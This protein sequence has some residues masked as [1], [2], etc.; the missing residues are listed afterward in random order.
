MLLKLLLLLLLLLRRL[1]TLLVMLE[2]LVRRRR[3]LRRGTSNA[4]MGRWSGVALAGRSKVLLL[5]LLLLRRSSRKIEVGRLRN[6]LRF[7]G[8]RRPRPLRRR[9]RVLRQRLRG[10][11]YHRLRLLIIAARIS[12][13][14][15]IL[16]PV[17]D[18][19][20]RPSCLI[21]EAAVDVYPLFSLL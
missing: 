5:L 10:V 4:T 9:R 1:L 6:S 8:R 20:G 16:F 17:G 14:F 11:H 15:L 7:G 12:L 3:S 2:L 18:E 21:D 19:H 13:Q